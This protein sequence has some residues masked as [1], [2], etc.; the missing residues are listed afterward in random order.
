MSFALENVVPWGRSFDEYAAIFALTE[1]DLTGRILGCGDGPASFNVE[2]T[3]R[4]H[5]VV[6]FDPIY[7]FEAADI[8]ARVHA[9]HEMIVGQLRQN[10]D[11]FVWTLFESPDDLG[12]VRLAAMRRFLADYDQGK[13]DGRYI[14][15]AL[16]GL[17]FKAD[18]FDLALSSHFL[19]LYS[20]HLTLEFHLASLREALRVARE[21]RVFPLLNLA[22]E[23]SPYLEPVMAALRGDGCTVELVKVDY[24][25]QRG[26]DT[27]L[28]V[29][30]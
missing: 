22:V 3:E 13:A 8:Q 10:V 30:R 1:A 4:G 29:A 19:F 17:P 12:R 5:T 2:A 14:T 26:G 18:S 28:R 20:A 24:E 25:F 7:Q 15:A 11:D 9:T 23:T 27:M 16:P 21:A 6:S